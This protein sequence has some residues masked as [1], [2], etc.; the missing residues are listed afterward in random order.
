MPGK[1][2]A[3][4]L[5]LLHEAGRGCPAF[6]CHD[7]SF[8]RGSILD[9]HALRGRQTVEF[10]QS[11]RCRLRHLVSV[12]QLASRDQVCRCVIISW[13]PFKGDF[14]PA[15]YRTRPIPS[16][17]HIHCLSLVADGVVLGPVPRQGVMW[18]IDDHRE[19]ISGGS[20]AGRAEERLPKQPDLVAIVVNPRSDCC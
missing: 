13:G 16:G 8:G 9:H 4:T 5:C 3:S 19:V 12:R 14:E 17:L 7:G 10:A 1:G 18:K 20:L 2:G 6:A 11:C 15:G